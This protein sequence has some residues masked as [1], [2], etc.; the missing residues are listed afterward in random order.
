MGESVDIM[1][2]DE[3]LRYLKDLPKQVRF[4]SS[5]AI[6][7]TAKEVQAFTVGELLPEKFTL[8]SK[9][10]PWQKPG[11]KLGF[12]IKFANKNNLEGRVGS[13]A[14]WLRLQEDGGEK[15]VAG[16]RV[17]IPTSYWKKK[18]EIMA[19]KKKPKALLA[20]RVRINGNRVFVAKMGSGM[21]GIFV[22]DGKERLKIHKL[23]TFVD[24]ADVKGALHFVESG[25]E[26]VRKNFQK[27]FG[28]ALADAL[29]T[30]K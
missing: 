18:A 10:T 9:G 6:N 7:D 11:N 13:Q 5:R 8:R 23:F 22:R 4:A 24:E 1:G 2:A 30:A 26:I 3:A 25:K 12:N 29:V 20:G 14:N 27:N 17:A 21:E 16:H 28:R 15:V 19:R